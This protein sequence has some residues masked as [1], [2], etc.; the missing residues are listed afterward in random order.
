MGQPE[1]YLGVPDGQCQ[2][3]PEYARRDT[4]VAFGHR[5]RDAMGSQEVSASA[6]GPR[7][8][9]REGTRV[10]LAIIPAEDLPRRI[11]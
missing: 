2:W 7:S 3:E 9:L 4:S 1:E 10:P 8:V 6:S 11:P 5:G